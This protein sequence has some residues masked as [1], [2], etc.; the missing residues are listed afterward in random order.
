MSAFFLSF[1]SV[2]SFLSFASCSLSRSRTRVATIGQSLNLP[3]D[4]PDSP[5]VLTYKW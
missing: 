4:S 2:L 1:F 5:E 3:D